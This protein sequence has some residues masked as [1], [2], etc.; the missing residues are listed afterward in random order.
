MPILGAETS[1]QPW[2][3]KSILVGRWSKNRRHQK[4]FVFGWL[5]FSRFC[6]PY[7]IL[8][9]IASTVP[10]TIMNFVNSVSTFV[11]LLSLSLFNTGEE[12]FFGHFRH[13]NYEHLI[14][15][16]DLCSVWETAYFFWYF[17]FRSASVRMVAW[18]RG[19]LVRLRL[20]CDSASCFAASDLVNACPRVL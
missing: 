18:F 2:L 15:H 8:L 11:H 19:N 7:P 1:W 10:K 13:C 17:L 20:V 9:E 4:I 5:L 6:Q 3:K 16:F 12:P 14:S